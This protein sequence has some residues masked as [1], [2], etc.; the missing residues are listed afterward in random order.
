[1]PDCVHRSG[2]RCRGDVDA[3][4]RKRVMDGAVRS[5]GTRISE[6]LRADLEVLAAERFGQARRV[7]LAVIDN[8]IYVRRRSRNAKGRDGE[9]ANEDV[10]N[11]RGPEGALRRANDGDERSPLRRHLGD[12]M[13]IRSYPPS[14]RV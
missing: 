6:V 12:S 9:G 4:C 3:E 11:S 10:I 8:R 5:L 14:C 1:M 2:P 7:L 13:L